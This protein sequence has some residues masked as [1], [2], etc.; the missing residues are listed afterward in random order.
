MNSDGNVSEKRHCLITRP[1]GL[2]GYA[3]KAWCAVCG[4]TTSNLSTQTCVTTDCPNVC[5]TDCLNGE[6]NFNCFNVDT[7]RS[8]FDI[9][10]AI[11]Y[12]EY[13]DDVNA[14]VN[15]ENDLDSELQ[16]LEKNELVSMI[17][18]LRAEIIKK[19]SIL[20]FFSTTT[21]DLANKRDAVVTVLDFIDNLLATK[22]SLEEL[23]VNSV[24]CS[25]CPEKIDEDWCTAVESDE[26]LKSWWES[27]K[28]K[29]LKRTCFTGERNEL[30]DSLQKKQH[31]LRKQHQ[32]LNQPDHQPREDQNNRQ[33]RHPHYQNHRQPQAQTR[34]SRNYRHP[35]LQNISRNHQ[36][37]NNISQDRREVNTFLGRQER[38]NNNSSR[39][40]DV[41]FCT[42][43]RK[44]GHTEN[45]CRKKV[46]CEYCSRT[47]HKIHDCRSKQ[48]EERQE[49]LYRN[50]LAEQ[51]QQNQL[52]MQSIHRSFPVNQISRDNNWTSHINQT[53][54]SSLPN[55]PQ[56]GH[57]HSYVNR[58]YTQL[59]SG[60]HI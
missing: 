58:G 34:G 36:Q 22:T 8:V 10:D 45:K 56:A 15:P 1:V 49:R 41:S 18:R 43:C 57:Q 60:T 14:N 48:Q 24:A 40:F 32:Q 50:I 2:P 9:P 51:N 59:H 42:F 19:N 27:G 39:G 44:R 37:L 20:S 21:A 17:K 29:K 28:P 4:K 31:N 13:S 54:Y 53:H 33:R 12:V 16:N 25:A 30:P 47:G 26:N 6:E 5:H 3:P 46:I 23:E 7:L 55:T 52:F 38:S 35:V 11:S